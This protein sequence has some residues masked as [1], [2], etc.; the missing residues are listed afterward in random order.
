[1][2]YCARCGN[3]IETFSS[4]QKTEDGKGVLHLFCWWK[5]EQQRKE[6]K[7]ADTIRQEVGDIPLLPPK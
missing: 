6:A 2:Q 3:G 5:L 4:R 7:D 1:M